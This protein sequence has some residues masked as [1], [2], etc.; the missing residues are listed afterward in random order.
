MI[1]AAT[2]IV[3][4]LLPFEWWQTAPSR[5]KNTVIGR[6]LGPY[7]DVSFR[8]IVL[9]SLLLLGFLAVLPLFLLFL[10]F[11]VTLVIAIFALR[12]LYLLLFAKSKIGQE[13]LL[14]ISLVLVLATCAVFG[15]LA[16]VRAA[17][18]AIYFALGTP[19]GG[20]WEVF[21]I[22][23]DWLAIDFFIGCAGILIVG[24]WLLIDAVWRL[25]Q[26]RQIENLA[27]STIRSLAIGLV[28][29]KGI[30][31]PES[32]TPLLEGDAIRIEWDM[33]RYLE[34]IQSIST[35][36]LDDG[37]G[38]VLV[39]ARDCKIRAGWITDIANLFGMREII[40]SK[41]VTRE[42]ARDSVIKTLCYGDEV[43]L[44]GNV[45]ID[46]AAPP[47]A[48][49]ADRLA[50]RPLSRSTWNASIWKALF[51]TVLPPRARD[52]QDVFFLADGDEANA[53][54]HIL[55]GFRT[56]LLISLLWLVASAGLIWSTTLPERAAP[57]LDSW[58][59]A[60]WQGPDPNP[61]PGVM[62]YTRNMRLFRFEKYI[63]SVGKTSYDQIPALI[64]A[65]G[66]KDYRFYE[67]ATTALLRMMPNAYNRAQE[68]L[69]LMIG[70]LDP[71][72]WNSEALQTMIIAVSLYGPD[73]AAAVPRLIID[74]ECRKTNT[75]AV[76]AQII[77]FQA[78]KALGRIGPAAKEAVPALQELLSSPAPYVRAEAELALKRIKNRLGEP[79]FMDD[80][81]ERK[82]L[83]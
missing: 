61:D 5:Q 80:S 44:I 19:A 54:K 56:V 41:R 13:P 2:L 43:Y 40:L 75:Y 66:Y 11:L 83:H 21:S 58:R 17:L 81:A 50:V 30:V 79:D 42:D 22:G 74:L 70:H 47:D 82:T 38:T 63:K 46:P 69:P 67:P 29:L 3:V 37:T 68:A 16:P 77:Q 18:V 25:R 31:R 1:Y 12:S 35:F 33:F 23:Q 15:V 62:D 7:L 59:N 14:G 20:F 4:L 51:G 53:R 39:D 36:R 60:F 32:G 45:E 34:P 28:E 10:P 27:T 24:L 73:A 52:V 55:R 49:G 57:R 48:I 64:E 9:R 78:A 8:N 26:A 6:I 65:I 76:T 71:C 72:S